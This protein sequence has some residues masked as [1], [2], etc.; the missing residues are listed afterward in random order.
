MTFRPLDFLA[1]TNFD[2]GA[3]GHINRFLTYKESE[4]AHALVIIVQTLP[5]GAQFP[6]L[7]EIEL[8]D[9]IEY[10]AGCR[11]LIVHGSKINKE[12]WSAFK[13]KINA[14]FWNYAETLK[15]AS[16]EF[17][18]L[19]EQMGFEKWREE[20]KSSCLVT[21][22]LFITKYREAEWA[23]KKIESI[24]REIDRDIFNRWWRPAW[25]FLE[26]DRSALHAFEQAKSSLKTRVQKFI[27]RLDDYLKIQREVSQSISKFER[28]QI[29]SNLD[30]FDRQAIKKI[31]EL[32][33]LR[34][35]NRKRK[36]IPERESVRALRGAFSID[37]VRRLLR[38]WQEAL[39]GAL[40]SRSIKMKNPSVADW[41]HPS[42]RSL[43]VEV[44]DGYKQ[45]A[46]TL[47]AILNHYRAFFLSTHPDPYIRSRFGF[48]EWIVAPEPE[49]TKKIMALIFKSEQQ[50]E[51]LEQ[52]RKG[53]VEGPPFKEE[54]NVAI[55]NRRLDRLLHEAMQPLLS[56]SGMAKIQGEIIE[57]LEGVGE[58]TSFS[59]ESIRLVQKGLAQAMRADWKYQ[60]LFDFPEFRRLY[61]THLGI[62]GPNEDRFQMSIQN[63]IK[64]ILKEL[65][66]W[67]DEH[68]THRHVH[69]IEE[70]MGNIRGV[71]Q[72]FLATSER[73]VK[74]SEM[75]EG[76][77][78]R[79][80]LEV[81]Y[82]FG[83]FFHLLL[84][85]GDEGRLLRIQFLFVDQYLEAIE[86]LCHSPV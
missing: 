50:L 25:L 58:L 71:L 85:S 63:R 36:I 18:L 75:S 26:L 78:S 22:Q 39:F 31:W 15:S 80:L 46:E 17:L 10:I 76:K 9:A 6:Y 12:E 62:L 74:G 21:E 14:A 81:R 67:I 8:S 2:E 42:V 40:Y 41:K 68:T 4:F 27:F 57:C 1:L 49:A 82:L 65:K 84:R 72:D 38:E 70:D 52:L 56:R 30:E 32:L 66:G 53:V 79:D 24:L 54:Q 61:A 5:K 64:D 20:L 45:E 86:N 28:F 73:A 55:V 19:L 48:S 51:L 33:K 43:V 60:T 29:F 59:V 7:A 69:E 35:L 3:T 13:D 77:L 34:T 37:E 47:L 11:Q 83:E 23:W 44:I 16:F